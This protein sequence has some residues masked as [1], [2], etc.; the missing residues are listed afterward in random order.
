M[1]HD[2]MRVSPLE[3]A[4]QSGLIYRAEADAKNGFHSDN[5]LDAFRFLVG[6]IPHG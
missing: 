3:V 6:N 1:A 2:T 5:C 4:A